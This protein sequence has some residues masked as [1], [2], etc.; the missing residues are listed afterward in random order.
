MG[1]IVP[2]IGNAD[3]LNCLSLETVKGPHHNGPD[4]VEGVLC[5]RFFAVSGV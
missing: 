2:L 1:L 4:S 3:A 5:F